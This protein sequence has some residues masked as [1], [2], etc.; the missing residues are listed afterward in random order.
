MQSKNEFQTRF[1][2]F[3]KFN[4]DINLGINRI[5][6]ISKSMRNATRTDKEFSKDVSFIEVCE[7]A[8]IITSSKLKNMEL[9]REFSLDFPYLTCNRSQMSQVIMNFLSNSADAIEE[10][11]SK[12]PEEIVEFLTTLKM[13]DLDESFDII[14]NHEKLNEIINSILKLG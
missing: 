12:H 1:E 8:I 6:E 3:Q 2:K 5:T 13:P 7:E 10:Y 4:D 14:W 9:I 11:K